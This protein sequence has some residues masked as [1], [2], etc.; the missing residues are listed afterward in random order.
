MKLTVRML[1]R[2]NLMPISMLLFT[3]LKRLLVLLT[4]AVLSSEPNRLLLMTLS[5]N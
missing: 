5:V 1:T 2:S 4:A 3:E